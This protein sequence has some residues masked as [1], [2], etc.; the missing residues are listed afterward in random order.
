[1]TSPHSL[2]VI[3]P[4][5]KEAAVIRDTIITLE[6]FLAPRFTAFEIIVVTDGSPD[7]TG[8]LVATLAADG[9]HPHLIHIAFP[10][11]R[12]KGA[13]VRAGVFRA[14]HELVLVIDADLT[15]PAEELPKFL[16]V[17]ED[18]DLAIASRLVSGSRFEEPSPWHRILLARGFYLLQ[19]V[20]LG[21]FE[22]SDT[23]C[24]FKLY[25]R[26]VAE[27][28]YRL[29][30]IDRF[31]TDAEILFLA[32]RLGY[33]VALL[34]VTVR[35]DPRNTNVRVVRDSLNMLG[36]LFKI[37]WYASLGRYDHPAH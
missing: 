13:A 9:T 17:I 19:M 20:L 34:P 26:P 5:Y 33:R 14:R 2:S 36:A 18:A 7:E 35:K 29:A 24:G 1:M 32:K 12:G 37:R 10:E 6:R 8:R 22:I 4:C 27:R 30:T 21:N 3:V 31:A 11:N 16:S 15:I 25:W 28:L 23:Q